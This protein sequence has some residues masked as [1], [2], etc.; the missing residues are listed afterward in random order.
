MTDPVTIGDATLY[1]GDCLE[2]LP[3]LAAGSVDAVVTDPPYFQPALHYSQGTRK[4]RHQRKISDLSV[5]EH[6]FS[7][8]IQLVIST[9]KETADAYVFCDGQSY[10]L[11]FAAWYS[12]VK[13][14][15]PL[16]W[17]KRGP[18]LGYNWR[19][20]HELI[21][22]AQMD[23]SPNRPTGDSDVLN[24]P[25]VPMPKRLHPAEKPTPLLRK[26]A[27]KCNP[28]GMICDPFMGSGA[29]GAARLPGQAFV[30]IESD[31]G[32]F[33]IACKRIEDAMTGGPLL[34]EAN[35]DA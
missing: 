13:S 9:M 34:A 11:L 31:P 1:R 14:I 4:K 2:I 21:A 33:D 16:V 6:F 10:P 22:F 28:T 18:V 30:G 26:I 29:V 19:H 23:Q 27:K 35:A 3:T 24:F 20:Q 17:V 7:S 5:L 32:Y 12:H 15:R 8:W 25:A